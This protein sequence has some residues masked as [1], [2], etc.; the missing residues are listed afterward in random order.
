MTVLYKG[1][2]QK[3]FARELPLKISVGSYLCF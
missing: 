3:A 2:S 1:S